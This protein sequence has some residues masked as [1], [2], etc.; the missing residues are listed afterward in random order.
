MHSYDYRLN[1]REVLRRITNEG[2]VMLQNNSPSNSDRSAK[3]K[4]SLN[5]VR[6]N[7]YQ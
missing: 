1:G 5:S 4:T 2:G 3:T 6:K 7:L